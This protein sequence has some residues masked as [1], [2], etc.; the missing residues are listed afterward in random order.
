MVEI[1]FKDRLGREYKYGEM[2]PAELSPWAYNEATV[3][4]W[5][6]VTKEK[7]IAEGFNWRDDDKRDYK[8]TTMVIPD[9]IGDVKEDI[10][11]AIIKCTD[12]G[13]NYQIIPAELT[14]LRQFK[15][16]VPR[17]CPLCRDRARIK[18]LNSMVIYNRNCAKCDR[19]IETS[20]SPDRPEIVYCEQCYQQEVV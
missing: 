13:K 4:E 17:Q 20:Y 9:N 19:P 7:A 3:Y 1:P 6:T 15:L 10:L 12:C 8:E 18:S 2:L 5:F 11:K 16:S 14:F